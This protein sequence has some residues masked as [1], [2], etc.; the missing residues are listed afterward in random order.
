[1]QNSRDFG[2]IKS[3]DWMTDFSPLLII[4]TFVSSLVAFGILKFYYQM[5]LL[6]PKLGSIGVF[7]A[8]LAAAVSQIARLGFG[9]AGVRDLSRGREYLG[10]GGII[11]S[12]ALTIYEHSEASRMAIHWGNEH[13]ALVFYFLVWVALVA[14][15]R[16]IMT[17]SEKP[18]VQEQKKGNGQRP[19]KNGQ[20]AENFEVN[21]EH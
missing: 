21:H 14:E 13:L 1:M 6:S 15:I 19:S 5:E 12:I 16:L 7:V 3:R 2:A 10:F 8:F 9:L 4:I 17:M 18:K 11:A 20:K